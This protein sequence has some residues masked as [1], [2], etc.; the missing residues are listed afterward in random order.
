[1][2]PGNDRNVALAVE[3]GNAVPGFDRVVQ[4]SRRN[5]STATAQ[6]PDVATGFSMSGMRE[7]RGFRKSAM[8]Q[9]QRSGNYSVV[10][11]IPYRV[12]S[13]DQVD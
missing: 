8:T 7:N 12:A 6:R 2:V 1:M 5:V 13:R 9:Y 3:T 10:G 11:P 4:H